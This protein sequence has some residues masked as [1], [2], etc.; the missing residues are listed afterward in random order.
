[1]LREALFVHDVVAAAELS[2]RVER[3]LALVG[4][5]P[6][7]A[8][9]YPHQFSGGQRQ[10]IGIARALSVEPELLV[11][12]EPVSALDVSVQA[13]V[14]NLLLDLRRELGL[15]LLL[16]AHD[17]GIV[18]HMAD[19]TAVMA[20]GRIVEHGSTAALFA[21]PAHDRTRELLEATVRTPGRLP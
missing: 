8:D 15:A 12:D 1:M 21:S 2:S 4:L 5:D 19:R 20:D 10:R 11:A 6:D 18:R 17:L 13:Q 9:R 16:V 7:S 14:L 3:L